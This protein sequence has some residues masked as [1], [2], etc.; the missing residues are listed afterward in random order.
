MEKFYGR[1]EELKSLEQ[2]YNKKRSSLVVIYGRRRI[3]KSA[4]VKHFCHNRLSLQFDGLENDST[5]DQIKYFKK[6]L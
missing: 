2:E 1:L 5:H 6:C 4:I 3:G